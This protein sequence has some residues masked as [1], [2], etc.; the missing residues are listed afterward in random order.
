MFRFMVQNISTLM[1]LGINGQYYNMKILQRTSKVLC[2]GVK[3][4]MGNRGMTVEAEHSMMTS[5]FPRKIGKSGEPGCI[6][7]WMSFTCPFLLGPV[8]FRTAITCSGD[9]HLERGGMPLHDAVGINCENYWIHGHR[10]EV[11]GL[12]G[13]RW[14]LCVYYQTWHDYSS[15]HGGGRKS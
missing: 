10:C 5:L 2:V 15:F 7:I 4:A 11:Y 9:Y 13:V 14:S 6:S 12:R 3:V 1:H 8:F